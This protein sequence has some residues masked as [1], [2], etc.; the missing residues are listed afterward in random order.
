[1]FQMKLNYFT[2]DESFPFFIQYGFHKEDL[3]LHSHE[4]FLE[5]VI[6]L[7]GSA[8]HIV[9][10]EDFYIS[11]G[12][13]FIIG[14]DTIHGYCNPKDFRICNLMF[15]PDF[16][17][18]NDCDI[19]KAP[20]F[21]GLFVIEPILSQKTSFQNRLKLDLYHFEVIQKTI[22]MMI[23]EYTNQG[24][25]FKTL[26]TGSFYSLAVL[27]SRLYSSLEKHTDNEIIGIAKSIAYIEEHYMDD[28][29]LNEL[30]K[31]AGFSPRH[32]SR[33]FFE[34]KQ[35]TPIHYIQALRLE[36]AS[37]Y[38]RNTQLPVS[39]VAMQ[40]GFSDSNYFSRSFKK[41]YA[42]TPIQF[43]KKAY[44]NVACFNS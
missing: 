43:H 40:C 35:T 36:K 44:K 14:A 8:T 33:R 42:I 19:K 27:L 11:K 28:L 32:F 20:G 41:H 5:L 37:Y 22:D 26:L 1:M 16:F 17:F 2:T 23:K 34:I 15:Q 4:N 9:N 7:S 38:L 21:Q 3:Y 31:I 10:N 24:L 30:A 39:E 6:V 18:S 29:T 13:V 12:D 25:G